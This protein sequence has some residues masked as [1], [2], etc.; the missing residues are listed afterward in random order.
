MSRYRRHG[1]LVIADKLREALDRW[2]DEFDGGDLDA[3]G[4]IIFAL[5]HIAEHTDGGA[6]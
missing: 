4:R 2:P 6:S 1:A 3:I 5:E